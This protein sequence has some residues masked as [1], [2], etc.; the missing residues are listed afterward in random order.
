MKF[1]YD[2]TDEISKQLLYKH[3]YMFEV[4]TILLKSSDK[5]KMYNQIEIP[6]NEVELA[7]LK[8][9]G[10]LEVGELALF[11]II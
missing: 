10:Q 5:S 11:V 9:Y 6:V 3:Y 2:V 1:E 8:N 7:V 4:G